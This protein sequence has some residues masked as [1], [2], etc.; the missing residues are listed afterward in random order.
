MTRSDG[1]VT[2]AADGDDHDAIAALPGLGAS[3]RR[4]LAAALA[5]DDHRTLVVEAADGT[6]VGAAIGLLLVDEAHVADVAVDPRWRRRGVA[7]ALL[8]GLLDELAAAGARA[9]TLEV[10]A[11]NDPAQLLYRRLGFVAEGRRPGYYPDGEDAV[12]MWRREEAPT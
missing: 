10:R 12:L 3:T 7:S 8:G 1:P 4:T 6:V 2:R 9:A 5:A 11:S